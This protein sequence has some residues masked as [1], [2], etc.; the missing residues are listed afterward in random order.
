[1][2]VVHCLGCAVISQPLVESLWSEGASPKVSCCCEGKGPACFNPVAGSSSLILLP[3]RALLHT[4]DC[5]QDRKRSP[6]RFFVFHQLLTAAFHYHLEIPTMSDN[7]CTIESDPGVFTELIENFGVRGVQVE[8]LYSLD[9]EV[10][11]AQLGPV[12]GMIF[13]F[14]WQQGERD[15]R[16]VQQYLTEPDL[17]FANQ[18]GG[19]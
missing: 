1:M 14:K 7:W 9:D 11:F 5:I 8:E 18:V 6:P 13:L 4:C 17:F 10:A 2:V 19:R 16:P 12:Y 15:D 3:P